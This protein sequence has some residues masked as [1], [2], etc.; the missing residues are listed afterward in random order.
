MDPHLYAKIDRTRAVGLGLNATTRRQ[1]HQ[2]QSE[3]IRASHPEFLDRS[4]VWDSLSSRS[5]DARTRS[6]AR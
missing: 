3:F 5:P 4:G 2:R 6:R 1:Q